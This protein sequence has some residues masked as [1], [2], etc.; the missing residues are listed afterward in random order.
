MEQI[1]WNIHIRIRGEKHSW[2]F[3]KIIHFVWLPT[4]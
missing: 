4:W 1:F 2:H 3:I